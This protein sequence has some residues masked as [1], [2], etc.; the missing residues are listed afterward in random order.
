MSISY[1]LPKKQGRVGK[2]MAKS[3]LVP[4]LRIEIASPCLSEGRL[5]LVMQE[6]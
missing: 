5:Q 6:A 2:P 4:K 1:G 3:G